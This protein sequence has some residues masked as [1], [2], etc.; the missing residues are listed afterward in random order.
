M[1]RV[2]LALVLCGAGCGGIAFE[3]ANVG[4]ELT[5]DVAMTFGDWL[6][7]TVTMSDTLPIV[8][9]SH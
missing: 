2:V 8:G 7:D 3:C 1:N 6:D 9:F 5:V 4:C